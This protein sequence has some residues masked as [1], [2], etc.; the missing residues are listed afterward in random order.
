MK[1]VVQRGLDYDILVVGQVSPNSLSSKLGLIAAVRDHPR[2]VPVL[3]LDQG[4]TL[5]RRE[6]PVSDPLKILDTAEAPSEIIA[7]LEKFIG[8]ED[9]L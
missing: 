3:I 7:A 5:E 8:V 9:P 4:G 1:D 2:A 6:L